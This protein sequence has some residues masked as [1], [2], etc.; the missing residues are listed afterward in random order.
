LNDKTHSQRSICDGLSQSAASNEFNDF[1]TESSFDG[2]LAVSLIVRTSDR[3]M[4]DW[5]VSWELN[6]T[7]APHK[8]HLVS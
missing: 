8:Y 2:K 4:T 1:E 5:L 7:S 6:G 3:R